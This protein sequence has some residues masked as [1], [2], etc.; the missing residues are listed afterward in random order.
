[1][2][3]GT[4]RRQYLGGVVVTPTHRRQGIAARLTRARLDWIAARAER[5]YYFTNER[6]RASV[7]L[8]ARFGFQELVRGLQVPGLTFVGGVGLLFGVDLPAAEKS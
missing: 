5:A 1:M 8:H 2:L 7:D 6:N 3:A 4:Q